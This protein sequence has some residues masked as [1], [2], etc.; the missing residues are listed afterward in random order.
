MTTAALDVALGS[1]QRILLDSSALIAFHNRGESAHYLARHLLNRIENDGDEIVGY[2]SVVSATEL[3]VRPIRA[4]NTEHVFMHSF[5]AS[6][7]HLSALTVDL[8]VATTAATLRA[9]R[10]V[11]LPD[12]LIIASGRLAGCDAIVTN[13]ASWQKQFGPLFREFQWL[14]LGDYV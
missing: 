12:A 5:L 10:N 7:P 6:F 8:S 13:D 14:Y 2:F 9:V 1:A 3:L 4:G 11:R